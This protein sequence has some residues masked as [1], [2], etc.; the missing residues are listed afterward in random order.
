MTI[1]SALRSCLC[2]GLLAAACGRTDL[3]L[4]PPDNVPVTTGTATGAGTGAAGSTTTGTSTGAAGSVDTGT[5]TGT[6]GAIG[7]TGA[8]G[9]RPTGVAGSVGGV[10]SAGAVGTAGTTGTAGASATGMAGRPG[11]PPPNQIPCGA[12]TC[13]AGM[14]TCC[15]RPVNG[16]PTAMCIAVGQTC[17]MGTSFSCASTA[18]CDPGSVCCV[19]TTNLSTTCEAP[20]A[21]L[22]SPGIILCG[23][24]SDCPGLLP[25]CCGVGNLRFCRARACAGGGGPPAGGGGRG[26]GGPPAGGG[27]P[28]RGPGG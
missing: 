17:D 21:C 8:G 20:A 22:L 12:E 13:F 7:G 9:A 15:V 2:A 18:S 6:A 27:G 24:D 14:Q 23:A 19:S 1:S 25:N 28:G 10:G 11:G 5:G 16:R 3:D 4:G 26:A